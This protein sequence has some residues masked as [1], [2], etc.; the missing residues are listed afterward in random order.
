MRKS[1]ELRRLA[2]KRRA[3]PRFLWGRYPVSFGAVP[4]PP[5]NPEEKMTKRVIFVVEPSLYAAMEHV[6]K[7]EGEGVSAWLRRLVR[8]ELERVDLM[9]RLSTRR[10]RRRQAG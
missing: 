7:R 6:A 2:A 4:R 8:E 10:G 5:K 9:P 1:M 3:K